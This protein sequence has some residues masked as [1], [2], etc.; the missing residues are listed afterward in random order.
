M[1][2]NP[3][4]PVLPANAVKLTSIFFWPLLAAGILSTGISVKIVF[5]SAS[6]IK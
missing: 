5:P 2:L 4:K 1:N 3:I 6:F